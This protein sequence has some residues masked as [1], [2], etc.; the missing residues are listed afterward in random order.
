MEQTEKL[1]KDYSNVEKG[2]YLGAISSIAT[3]D[4]NASEEE[5]EYIDALAESAELSDEQREAVRRAA[6]E[7]TGEE[8]NKCLDVL[9]GSEL[10]F[11]LITDLI[12]FAESDQNYT[13]EEKANIDKIAQYLNI[14]KEQYAALNQFVQKT[15]QADVQPEQM[16]QQGFLGS[17]GLEDKFKS[18]GINFGSLTKGLLGMVGPM[19][20]GGMLSRGLGG[21]RGGGLGGMLGGGLGGML[22]GGGGLGGML[23]GRRGGGLG[24]LTSMLNGGRGF[25]STGGLLSRVLKGL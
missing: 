18:A 6:T 15:T 7:I 3:A 13:P 24:S 5:L 14:N 20:L 9:K 2:A 19:I 10:R 16:Q 25:G 17:L 22:G 4:R 8:L 11:S 23:G 1:L 21:R 12:A